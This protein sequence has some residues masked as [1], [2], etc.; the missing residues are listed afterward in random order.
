VCNT[1]TDSLVV[2]SSLFSRS[3]QFSQKCFF[4]ACFTFRGF[5]SVSWPF[6]SSVLCTVSCKGLG[7][8]GCCIF[9][10]LYSRS[11]RT[12]CCLSTNYSSVFQI[13]RL[14]T[15]FTDR[16]FVKTLH[17]RQGRIFIIFKGRVEKVLVGC[18]RHH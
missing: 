4:G 11:R 15:Y 18:K 13:I 16:R 9:S 7:R 3:V 5:H 10:M 2:T 14:M 1:T 17:S 8:S 12:L 6:I